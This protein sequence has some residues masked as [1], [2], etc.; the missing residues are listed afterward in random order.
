VIGFSEV[1]LL[2]LDSTT[3]DGPTPCLWG[4]VLSYVACLLLIVS[5]APRFSEVSGSRRETV[6]R[7]N[8]FLRKTVQT[9]AT[10]LTPGGLL[11]NFDAAAARALPL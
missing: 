1:A 4:G 10:Y 7:F 3:F 5:L 8:G 6:S 9:A 11:S 2:N